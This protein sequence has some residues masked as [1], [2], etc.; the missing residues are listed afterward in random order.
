MRH[1]SMFLVLKLLQGKHTLSVSIVTTTEMNGGP[2]FNVQDILYDGR[3]RVSLSN[4][5]QKILC[6]APDKIIV[7]PSDYHT[8]KWLIIGAVGCYLG[9]VRD[10]S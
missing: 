7:P 9:I 5:I 2:G 4:A 6:R 3:W 8:K 1:I 10:E